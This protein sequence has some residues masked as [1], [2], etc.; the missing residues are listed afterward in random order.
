[1]DTR[2]H[3]IINTYRSLNDMR[4]FRLR[5]FAEGIAVGCAVGVIISGFRMGLTY[6]DE[7]RNYTYLLIS[8]GNNIALFGWLAALILTVIIL[9]K[10]AKYEPQTVG[11][12]IPQVKGAIAGIVKLRWKRILPL[13][14]LACLS[15]IGSG[16]SLGRA[17]PSIQIGAVTAQGISRLLGRVSLEERYLLSSGAGAGLAAVFNAPLS[18]VIFVLEELQHNFSGVLLFPAL[19]A[20]LTA[21][22]VSRLL[23]GAETVFAFSDLAV[24][25]VHYYF[26]VALISFICALAG[27]AFNYSLLNINRF[28][29]L[30]VFKN[31][32]LKNIFVIACAAVT[33]FFLP[34]VLGG[35]DNLAEAIHRFDYPLS[36]LLLFLIGKVILTVLS[37]GSG[38]AGGAFIPTLVIGSLLGGIG[39]V[40]LNTAGLLPNTYLDNIL[41]VGMT[42]FFTASVRTP[43][44]A[45]V[46]VMEM[47]GSFEHLL[48]L[49]ISSLTAFVTSEFCKSKPLYEELLHRW[50]RKNGKQELLATEHERNIAELVAEPGSAVDGKHIKDIVW[51]PHTLLVDIKRGETE[52]VPDGNTRICS[53]D[54]I[55]VLAEKESL[56]DLENLTRYVGR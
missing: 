49:S 4:T 35:G 46:L 51:P 28:Y 41:V 40:I 38:I 20:T 32:Y 19:A 27:V 31:A 43:I 34:E 37:F 50:L 36:V 2:H 45:T 24:L 6:L 16:L 55:Y 56:E 13:K 5:L 48:V 29:S 21:T 22:L 23:C 47:T 30:P 1:M 42:A 12:G 52:I 9:T 17:G 15:A 8:G 26:Y 54:C 11:S 33:G 10:S 7:L 3:R 18:G 14:L 53:G 25:P 39:A 44:S